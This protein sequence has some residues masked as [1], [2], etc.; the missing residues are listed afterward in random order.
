[1]A[2]NHPV[3]ANACSSCFSL[4]WWTSFQSHIWNQH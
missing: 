4:F 1:M 3:S 2:S